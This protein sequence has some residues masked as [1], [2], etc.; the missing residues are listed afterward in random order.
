LRHLDLY[1]S[2]DAA[3]FPTDLPGNCTLETVTVSCNELGSDRC[4]AVCESLQE[5]CHLRE[6]NL[7]ETAISLDDTV[8]TALNNLLDSTSIRV[9]NLDDNLAT[10]QG[11]AALTDGLQR[12][13][14]LRELGLDGC[15]I[16]NEGLL[17]LGEAL[18]ENSTLEILRLEGNSFDQG[19]L[20]QFF[21]LL[22]MMDG[23]EDLSLDKAPG[24]VEDELWSAVVNGLRD[25][26]SLQSL[27]QSYSDGAKALIDFYLKLNRNGRKY[28]KTSLSSRIPGGLRPCILANMASTHDASLLFYFLQNKPQLVHC[29]E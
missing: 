9:L 25:N 8:V 24:I 27:T 17:H 11:I 28:L 6:L 10:N 1:A 2:A 16:G 5:N 19:T 18:V 3:G 15:E 14:S 26:T 29:N 7:D 4:R 13:S 23:L 12:N 22:P 20:F 21:Q